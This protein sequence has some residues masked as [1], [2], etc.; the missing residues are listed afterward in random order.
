MKP[1]YNPP[2]FQHPITL[3]LSRNESECVIEDWMQPTAESP[4]DL[5][6]DLRG[7]FRGD[8]RGDLLSRYP[9]QQAL[10]QAIGAYLGIDPGRI[11]ITAGGDE[12]M[13][14]MIRKSITPQRSVVVS[15]F[16]SFEM[17]EVY[18]HLCSGTLEGVAWLEGE[19]PEDRLLEKID[20]RT[21]LVVLVTPNNPTGQTIPV[22]NLLRVADFAAAA[23]VPLLVDHA[24]VEFAEEDPT[25]V[26]VRHPN[27]FI[28]RTFSKAWGLAGQ[29]VGYLIT[30]T[31][32]LGTALRDLAGPFPVSGWSLE[33]ARRSLAGYLDKMRANVLQVARVR[34]LLTDLLA[35]CGAAAIPSEGNFVLAE[36]ADSDRVW[37]ELARDGIGVRKF[38]GSPWL[39]NH[40]RITCPVRW[41]DYLRLVKSLCRIH[42]LDFENYQNE[43]LEKLSDLPEPCIRPQVEGEH[44][45][46]NDLKE[47]QTAVTT[48]RE[49]KET[50]IELELDLYGTGQAQ[51]ET[52]IGFLDHM[53]TALVFHSKMNLRLKCVGD[54]QV[55]DH[56]TSEDCAIALGQALDRAL[57]NRTGIRRFGFAY[58]PLDESLART[59]LDLSARP[60][61]EIHLHLQREQIGQWACENI[62][63]FFQSL[64]MTLRCSLHLDVLRGSNDHHRVEAAFKSLALA[65][66]QAVTRTDFGIPSTKGTL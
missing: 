2:Q 63:H 54:L 65:L 32:E 35:D 29:R 16:P 60:W 36:F 12:S 49:T 6:G 50:R 5:L 62:V 14:R 10:Q 40:L 13:D 28:V 31:V 53:L 18:T 39:R 22:E 11:V 15:H 44:N 61:P 47:S 55:D 19:F 52:G 4:S 34:S 8:F 9:S 7:D 21:A 23:G 17:I 59:V 48:K 66:R 24:Y 27:V 64:A 37:E 25:P 1:A 26:L 43:L 56:H 38:S 3:Q 42:E 41:G 30:P 46:E 51:I 20:N 57:G 58:A 45:Q 33:L